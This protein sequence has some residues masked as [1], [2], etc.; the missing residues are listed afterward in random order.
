MTSKTE[1]WG[2]DAKLS[3]FGQQW[4]P[5]KRVWGEPPRNWLPVPAVGTLPWWLKAILELAVRPSLKIKLLAPDENTTTNTPS[6][7]IW[8]RFGWS[9]NKWS[10]VCWTG[11]KQ[12]QDGNNHMFEVIATHILLDPVL[13]EICQSCISLPDLPVQLCSN[14]KKTFTGPIKNRVWFISINS[15]WSPFTIICLT[16]AYALTV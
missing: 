12:R 4:K 8:P 6:S 2:A 16:V 13:I 5:I 11:V 15:F 1:L 10:C 9:L 7:L 14:E 3:A